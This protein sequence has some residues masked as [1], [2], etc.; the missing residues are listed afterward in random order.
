MRILQTDLEKE[1]TVQTIETSVPQGVAPLAPRLLAALA[2][3]FAY[4]ADFAL[5][6]DTGT[7]RADIGVASNCTRATTSG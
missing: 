2:I 6:D 3:D 4:F 5:V 1:L 7:R